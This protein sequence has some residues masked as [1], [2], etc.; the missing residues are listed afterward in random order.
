MKPS[1]PAEHFPDFDPEA[2]WRV[3]DENA[4][5]LGSQLWVRREFLGDE[6]TPLSEL[7]DSE[8]GAS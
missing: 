8:A 5:A 2:F 6:W 3:V 7:I 4:R 1:R